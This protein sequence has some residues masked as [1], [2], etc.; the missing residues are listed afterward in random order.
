M[1]I[2]QKCIDDMESGR[3]LFVRST[4]EMAK[5]RYLGGVPHTWAT[6]ADVFLDTMTLREI[7]Q[8]VAVCPY[9]LLRVVAEW[10]DQNR[11]SKNRKVDE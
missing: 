9:Q 2:E 8:E 1:T 10:A 5:A 4:Y 6:D 7:A 11:P 3:R